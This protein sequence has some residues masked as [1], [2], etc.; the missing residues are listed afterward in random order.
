MNFI[1]DGANHIADSIINNPKTAIAVPTATAALGTVSRLAEIQSWL[2]V[3]S[4]GMGLFISTV[5][6]WHKI[7][8]L[9]TAHVEHKEAL[10]RLKRHEANTQLEENRSSL[11]VAQT[12]DIE[13]HLFGR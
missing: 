7:V 3:V 10:L 6:L 2:T 9:K 12:H 8:Q 1:K 5:I 11:M 4:M 13:R